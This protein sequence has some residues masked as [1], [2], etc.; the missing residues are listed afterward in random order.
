MFGRNGSSPPE[1]PAVDP[2][3]ALFNRA[4]TYREFTHPMPSDEPL[5]T[6][7]ALWICACVT[8]DDAPIWLIYE[9]GDS[10]MAWCRVPDGMDIPDVVA[11]DSVAGGHADPAEVLAWLQGE[12]SDPWAGGGDG[13]R[14]RKLD[15]FYRA[16]RRP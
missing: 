12:A 9:D 13:S 3:E 2:V 14:G 15:R 5:A 4:A 10:G 11:A 7:H 6:T 1:D 16:L 8:M